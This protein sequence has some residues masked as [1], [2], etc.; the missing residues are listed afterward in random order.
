MK[1][2]LSATAAALL[3]ASSIADVVTI[4]PSADATL[5]EAHFERNTGANDFIGAGT[6]GNLLPNRE[7]SRTR[8]LIKFDLAGRIPAGATITISDEN[9][10]T[11]TL[12]AKGITIDSGNDLIL[13]AKGAVKVTGSTIDLN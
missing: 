7:F 6:S 11:I 2:A 8:A 10:N 13:K 5:H 9:N 4:N 3:V 12:D 1:L